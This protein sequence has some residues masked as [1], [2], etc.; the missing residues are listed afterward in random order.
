MAPKKK[1]SQ[2]KAPKPKPRPKAP[3]PERPPVGPPAGRHTFTRTNGSQFTVHYVDPDAPQDPSQPRVVPRTYDIVEDGGTAAFITLR[4][5]TP[6]YRE[7]IRNVSSVESEAGTPAGSFVTLRYNPKRAAAKAKT[8]HQNQDDSTS[9]DFHSYQ[10]V[11]APPSPEATP[12]VQ[13]N[14]SAL[15]AAQE[16]IKTPSASKRLVVGEFDQETPSAQPDPSPARD[17]HTTN[18]PKAPSYSPVTPTESTVTATDHSLDSLLLSQSVQQPQQ[19]VP[20]QNNLAQAL[21]GQPQITSQVDLQPHTVVSGPA[22]A[23]LLPDQ[24][25]GVTKSVPKRELRS[26]SRSATSLESPQVVSPVKKRKIVK[27]KLPAGYIL[28][29]NMT[30]VRDP[31]DV[32]NVLKGVVDDL[33]DVQS[34]T[35]GFIPETQNLLIDKIGDLTEKLVHLKDLTDPQVSPN[36]PIHNVRIAPEIVDYVDEGRNPDIFTREFVENVQRGNAVINGKKQAFKDFSVIYAQKLKEGI[37]GV[38]RQVDRIMHNAGLDKELGEAM[39][40]AQNADKDIGR[41]AENGEK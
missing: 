35:H 18:S 30:A 12:S 22:F 11:E 34:K 41:E 26:R 4:V 1:A 37:G 7:L 24:V 2:R 21:I 23:P 27:L 32:S 3:P 36:N 6:K 14:A 16:S 17:E 28:D 20:T 29:E 10:K 31:N 19:A 13:G 39:K 38:D 33:Y 40:K 8:G 15:I 25:P 9:Y 5:P